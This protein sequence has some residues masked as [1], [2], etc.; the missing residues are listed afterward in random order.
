MIQLKLKVNSE[1]FSPKANNNNYC[2]WN[3]KRRY[4]WTTEGIFHGV[5]G[6][7]LVE[8]IDPQGDE[9]N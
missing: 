9:A 7:T 8:H 4:G 5:D 3:E 1:V 2:L 6:A